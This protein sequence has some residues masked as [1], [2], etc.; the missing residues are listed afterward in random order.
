[1]SIPELERLLE[2]WSNDPAFRDAIRRDPVM[3]ITRAGYQLDDT[4]WAAIEQTDWS[5][6][7]DQLRARMA[8]VS[9]SPPA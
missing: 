2:R 7:D 4:E 6:P 5:L 9:A 1:M 8:N 3:A